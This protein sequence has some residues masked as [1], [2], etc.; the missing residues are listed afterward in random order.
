MAL[1]D[2]TTTELHGVDLYKIST[3]QEY[4]FSTTCKGRSGTHGAAEFIY[5]KGV[6]STVEGAVVTY[7]EVGI[8]T[9]LAANAK[10][11]VAVALGATVANT[12]G[13]YGIRGKFAALCAAASADNGSVGYEGAAFTIGDGRAAGDQIAGAFARSATDTP[14]AGK[15]WVQFT[16]IP[17]CDDFIGA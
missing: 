12:Y 15:C 14:E 6:A 1:T 7:D 11:P 17:Y 13:W 10:G 5:L 4:P 9:A 3:T 8:T 16:C 2:Y